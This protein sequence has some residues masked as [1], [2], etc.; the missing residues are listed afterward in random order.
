MQRRNKVVDAAR[1]I[2]EAFDKGKGLAAAVEGARRAL[3]ERD[4]FRVES[5][6]SARTA[7]ATSLP[8]SDRSG[9][10]AQKSR[11]APFRGTDTSVYDS[12][13]EVRRRGCARKT[14]CS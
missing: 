7:G 11:V 6:G 9:A 10:P 4:R 8:G 2:V 13:R 14:G 12:M 3:D 1:S 5:Y